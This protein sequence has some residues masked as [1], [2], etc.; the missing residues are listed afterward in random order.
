MRN[1]ST[2]LIFVDKETSHDIIS[3]SPKIKLGDNEG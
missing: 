3:L 1:M 2:T